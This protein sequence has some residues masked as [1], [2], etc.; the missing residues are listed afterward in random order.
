MHWF[1]RSFKT[2]RTYLRS[3]LEKKMPASKAETCRNGRGVGGGDI[4]KRSKLLQSQGTFF[5]QLSAVSNAKLR[6]NAFGG[7][8]FIYIPM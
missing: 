1:F 4:M 6:W 7:L 2:K 5:L 3:S 8:V